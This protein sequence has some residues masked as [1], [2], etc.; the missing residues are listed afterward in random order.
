[1]SRLALGGSVASWFDVRKPKRAV[2]RRRRSFSLFQGQERRICRSKCKHG[3]ASRGWCSRATP[4]SC[5][6]R[7]P[8]QGAERRR[9][10]KAA[11]ASAAQHNG[12]VTAQKSRSLHSLASKKRTR[13]GSCPRQSSNRLL[14]LHP[15]TDDAAGVSRGGQ[16]AK[17]LG[18]YRKN[19]R[20]IARPRLFPSAG[21][22]STIAFNFGL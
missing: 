19:M 8:G 16:A 17:V 6:C 14:A 9:P 22:G 7:R 12:R 10:D 18:H 5:F 2:G 11:P 21:R 20:Q 4:R 3:S 15:K 13:R 1:M